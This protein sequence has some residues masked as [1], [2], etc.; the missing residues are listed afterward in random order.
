MEKKLNYVYLKKIQEN[1][2]EDLLDVRGPDW[3][4]FIY[5]KKSQI[6]P[7]DSLTLLLRDELIKKKFYLVLVLIYACHIFQK[8]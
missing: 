3:R 1:D 6:I 5:T 7:K 2:I 8:V 4:P